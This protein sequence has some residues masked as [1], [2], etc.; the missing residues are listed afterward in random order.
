VLTGFVYDGSSRHA[1]LVT[2]VRKD[3][4]ILHNMVS[5]L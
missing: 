3:Q 4:V 2:H 1:H 5:E